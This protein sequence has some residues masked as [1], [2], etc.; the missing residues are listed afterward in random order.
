MTSKKN[1]LFCAELPL[2]KY[3]LRSYIYT[4]SKWYGGTVYEEQLYKNVDCSD[5]AKYKMMLDSIGLSSF[6]RFTFTI[7]E[8]MPYYVGQWDFSSGIVSFSSDKQTADEKLKG[9]IHISDGA[10]AISILPQ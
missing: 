4:Q 8:V 1:S 9:L 2:G 3:E 10:K 6:E 7:S 5:S